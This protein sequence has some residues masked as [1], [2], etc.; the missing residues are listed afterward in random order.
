MIKNTVSCYNTFEVIF[1]IISH[2]ISSLRQHLTPYR[3]NRGTLQYT[4][5][6]YLE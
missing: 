2:V 4:F 1:I 6:N 5:T 3:S